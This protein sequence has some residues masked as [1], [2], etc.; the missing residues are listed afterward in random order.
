M[1]KFFRFSA[2]LGAAA[3][4]LLGCGSESGSDETAAAPTTTEERPARAQPMH[5]T[6]DGEPGPET[7]GLLTAYELGYFTEAGIDLTI[8]SPIYPSRP[9]SYVIGGIEVGISHEPQ[10]ALVQD[11]GIPLVAIGSLVTES[12]LSMIW[13]EKS[14]ID[15]IADLK[16]KT[17]GYP[18]V[19][20]QKELLETVLEREGLELSDVELK[21]AG[22][23]LV[24]ELLSGRVD[25]IFG[26]SWNVEGAA[27]ETRGAKPVI[28]RA[29][30]LEIPPYNELVLIAD[31]NRVEKEP[32]MFRRFVEAVERGTAAAIEDPEAAVDAIYTRSFQAAD[33]KAT[34]AGVELTLPLLS[35]SGSIDPEQ[36]SDLIDWMRDEG[37]IEDELSASA[38]AVEP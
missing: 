18:G 16:G 33:P 37:L 31:E 25:A 26:G 34:R 10:I 21:W 32:D 27:L 6:L 22:Y 12:T 19:P 14:G 29:S 8:S 15:D 11:K 9:T 7:A 38:L 30:E 2:A 17:I 36:S 3:V 13:L 1:V 24:P 20:F 28:L 5:V 4:L 23:E 35:E